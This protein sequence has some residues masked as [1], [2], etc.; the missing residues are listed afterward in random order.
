MH[1]LRHLKPF[2][3]VLLAV[4]WP[5]TSAIAADNPS[6]VHVL[7]IDGAIGPATADYVIRGIEGAEESGAELVVLRMDTPGG[8]DT[9]MRDMIKT[10]LASEVPVAGFVAPGGSRAASAG[11]YLL[12]A[13]HIAAMAPATNL[14][15]ATPVQIGGM[16]GGDTP[17]DPGNGPG[18]DAGEEESKETSDQ[19]APA[20]KTAS[21]RKAINDAVAYIRGLAAK[22]GRNAD[23]AERAVREAVSLPARDALERNVIDLIAT[24]LDA[25]LDQVDGMNIETS[26]GTVT[27]DTKDARVNEVEPDWRNELLSTITNPTVAYLLMLIG[28]YGLIFEGYSPGALVPGIIGAISLLLA[29]YAFQVLPVNS[30]GLGLILLGLVLMVAEVFAPSF[31]ALGLGGIVAFVIGSVILMDT[32]VPGYSIPL[33]LILGISTTGALVVGGTLYLLMRSRQTAY[34]SGKEQLLGGTA[35]A[36]KNFKGRG[37]VH[38]HGESWQAD[39]DHA[40]TRGQELRVTGIDGLVLKVEPITENAATDKGEN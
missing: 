15:A 29:L 32:D 23:W 3:L 8:L 1:I 31:G 12:Y 13:S 17:K 38:I 19:G 9:A 34:S 33:P 18:K 25:L 2:A 22:R 10:I 7:D 20:P 5:M 6:E 37:L 26:T 28:I 14:G 40:V 16:P 36:R 24:D 30:A 11:T 4:A 39:C 35:V 27:L 21:E